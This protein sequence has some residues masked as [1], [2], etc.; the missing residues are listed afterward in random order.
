[1]IVINISR[2]IEHQ[3]NPIFK[4]AASI[5]DTHTLYIYTCIY[6]CI[7]LAKFYIMKQSLLSGMLC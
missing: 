1:M 7:Y 6:T 3:N 4:H 2:Y 5:M